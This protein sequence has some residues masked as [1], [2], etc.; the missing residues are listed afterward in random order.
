MTNVCKVT[1]KYGNISW[2]CSLLCVM[3]GNDNPKT[4]VC[5]WTEKIW[6]K[7][8]NGFQLLAGQQK[9]KLKI[10]CSVFFPPS[11]SYS[12][13]QKQIHHPAGWSKY[14]RVRTH[15]CKTEQRQL[16]KIHAVWVRTWMSRLPLCNTVLYSAEHW[17][18]CVQAQRFL[19]ASSIRGGE[20]KQK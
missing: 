18:S 17:L 8:L 10:W 1:W 20:T 12:T 14:E 13:P 16:F 4:I 11:L 7:Q 2:Q 5:V 15:T 19:P 9:I 3:I 6:F